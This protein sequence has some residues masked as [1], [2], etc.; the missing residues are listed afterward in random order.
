[1]AL[2]RTGCGLSAAPQ[3][4]VR[5]VPDHPAATAHLVKLGS[6]RNKDCH[7]ST[8]NPVVALRPNPRLT[9]CQTAQSCY[10]LEAIGV[11]HSK[12]SGKVANVVL[13]DHHSD[14]V[15]IV[16]IPWL[17]DE[18]ASHHVKCHTTVS[19]R[20]TGFLKNPANIFGAV[21]LPDYLDLLVERIAGLLKSRGSDDVGK[22]R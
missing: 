18:D 1:M 2:L 22:W 19:D 20:H 4:G 5:L 11:R 10:A 8:D 6:L 13:P 17:G 9:R 3:S 15:R 12:L 14:C 21:G 16:L 7:A